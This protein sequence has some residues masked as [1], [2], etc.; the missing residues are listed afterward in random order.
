MEENTKLSLDDRVKLL[1]SRRQTHAAPTEPSPTCKLLRLIKWEAMS[2]ERLKVEDCLSHL[3]KS[4]GNDSVSA[5]WTSW[6]KSASLLLTAFK[7]PV[8]MTFSDK[9]KGYVG[10]LE[11]L[12]AFEIDR[13]DSHRRVLDVVWSG[14]EKGYFIW[15][16]LTAQLEI[17][18]V[19]LGEAQAEGCRMILRTTIKYLVSCRNAIF[20]GR[21][22][23]LNTIFHTEPNDVFTKVGTI[24]EKG[25]REIDEL[26]VTGN[27]PVVAMM[28]SA[29]SET[30]SILLKNVRKLPEI[31]T[32]S[33]KK[34]LVDKC[35]KLCH[36][37]SSLGWP[38][39]Q[40]ELNKKK[41]QLSEWMKPFNEKY[42]AT[43]NFARANS[44][45]SLRQAKHY[46][47]RTLLANHPELL[48][49]NF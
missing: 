15:N 9:E 28:R 48:V 26:E 24:L 27:E 29:K 46:G 30:M 10:F 34:G 45:F 21:H 25:K 42:F 13:I 31:T 37:I 16:D 6:E 44:T 22:I 20:S 41:D 36:Q 14:R 33:R 39:S 43:N 8:Y 12:F 5:M 7:L 19:A 18:E 35:Y 49:G 17:C 1:C 3:E 40:E 38:E 47:R 4:V 11:K 23:P 32:I 2:G